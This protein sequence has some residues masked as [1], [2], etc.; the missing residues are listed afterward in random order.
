MWVLLAAGL[1]P[2]SSLRI[3]I[4]PVAGTWSYNPSHSHTQTTDSLSTCYWIFILFRC[5]NPSEIGRERHSHAH[6]YTILETPRP[7]S[8]SSNCLGLFRSL[9][10]QRLPC[11]HP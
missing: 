3:Q 4:F 9:N 7:S 6:T 11:S 1:R 2:I 10:S 8:I 5:L